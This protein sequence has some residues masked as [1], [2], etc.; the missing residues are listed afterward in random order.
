MKTA[1]LMLM[2]ILF[3]KGCNDESQNDVNSA[4]IEYTANT[5]GFYGNVVIQNKTVLISKDRDKKAEPSTAVK[6]SDSDLKEL[7]TAFQEVN[8]EEIPNLK[9]PTEKRFYDGAAIAD[10]SI[11]Y[12]G[13]T[14]QSQAFDHGNPPVE[15]EKLVNKVASYLKRE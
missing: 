8:L 11:T 13:K 3:G 2:V 5:R 9:S 10:L 6:I 1:A 12:Q 14:Y 7:V 4:I 15:I